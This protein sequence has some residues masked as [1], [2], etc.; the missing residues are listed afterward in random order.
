MSAN[1]V[2]K[3]SSQSKTVLVVDDDRAARELLERRLRFEGFEVLSAGSAPDALECAR[4]TPPDAIVA[5]IVMPG[6]DGFEFCKSIRVEPGLRSVPVVL[7]SGHELLVA[8]KATALR[9]GASR[10]VARSNDFSAEVGALYDA[11]RDTSLRVPRSL[12]HDLTNVFAAISSFAHLL[13]RNPAAVDAQSHLDGVL[14]ACDRGLRIARRLDPAERCP[15]D[16]PSCSI[17][18]SL[19]DVAETLRSAVG[20]EIT[21]TTV[22]DEEVA[23][24]ATDPQRTLQLLVNIALLALSHVR[25]S[26]TLI[27]HASNASISVPACRVAGNLIR[28]HVALSFV[29][30]A[31][32][33]MRVDSSGRRER[34][35]LRESINTAVS[36]FGGVF[37]E[38]TTDLNPGSWSLMLPMAV[39]S[40]GPPKEEALM[41]RVVLLVD[42]DRPLKRAIGRALAQ[43]G[44]AVR[45]AHTLDGVDVA[46]D[47]SSAPVDFLLLDVNVPGL[48]VTEVV[49]RVRRRYPHVRIAT[50]SG[51]LVDGTI[52]ARR[53]NAEL[54]LAKPVRTEDLAR[55]ILLPEPLE[56]RSVTG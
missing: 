47:S 37:A 7:M 34:G 25:S 29:V 27:V 41:R 15:S 16:L 3:L 18:K 36:E 42:D 8:D 20:D 13:E 45:V 51:D 43:Y 21:V 11:I 6:V 17:R 38:P 28:P 33:G 26:G 54:F 39:V 50:T 49:A 12:V 24:S 30:V 22:C 23:R 40:T 19:E 1:P 44:I 48:D 32:L 31:P 14:A 56:P 52:L 53:L 9:A 55:L 46:I 5:D 2:A 35:T 4:L 10:V